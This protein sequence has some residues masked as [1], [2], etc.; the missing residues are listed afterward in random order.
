MLRRSVYLLIILVL[1]LSAASVVLADAPS[2]GTVHEG[3][4]VPGITLGDTRAEV[5]SAYGPPQSC[6]S[7]EAPSDFAFCKFDVEGGGSVWTRYRGPDGGNAIGS[8]LLSPKC[9]H[10]IYYPAVY[11]GFHC[12]RETRC[13]HR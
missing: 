4:S 6:S 12:L 7:V 5:E 3:T 1:S 2:A 8:N 9:H 13:M 11:N 10:A